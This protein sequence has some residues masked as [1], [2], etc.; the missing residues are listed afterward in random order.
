MM[1]PKASSDK[2]SDISMYIYSQGA[3]SILTF[4]RKINDDGSKG[5]RFVLEFK[6]GT[7]KPSYL[8]AMKLDPGTYYLDSF[9]INMSEY[10]L[11]SQA[12][13]YLMR[14][15]WDN[16]NKQPKYLSFVVGENQNISLPKVEIIA[17]KETETKYDFSFK[18][19]TSESN[20]AFTVGANRKI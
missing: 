9:Q 7:Y 4:W 5:R 16:D 18:L 19:D 2:A 17:I 3:R 8:R 10:F 1:R 15:G 13:H 11:V 12:V 14:N 6:G 20:S